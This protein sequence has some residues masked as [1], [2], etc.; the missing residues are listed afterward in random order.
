M[1]FVELHQR[2]NTLSPHMTTQQP[3]N[4]TAGHITQRNEMDSLAWGI[5][6]SSSCR[7]NRLRACDTINTPR[8]HHRHV[9]LGHRRL[10]W[11][12]LLWSTGASRTDSSRSR[13][14]GGRGCH[15]PVSFLVPL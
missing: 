8:R 10:S 4:T 5:T 15:A 2:V 7:T 6:W 13:D 3:I 1:D 12:R 11:S 14:I 9:I